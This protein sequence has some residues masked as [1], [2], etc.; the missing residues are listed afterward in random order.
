MTQKIV[1][2]YRAVSPQ[3][4]ADIQSTGIFRPNPSGKSYQHFKLFTK[5][6]EEAKQFARRFTEWNHFLY[7]VIRIEVPEEAITPYLI[8]MD[9]VEVYGIPVGSALDLINQTKGDLIIISLE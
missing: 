6:L 7:S 3:E 2:I 5:E 4:L 8:V 1:R 9:F